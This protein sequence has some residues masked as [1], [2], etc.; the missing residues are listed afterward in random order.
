VTTATARHELAEVLAA[1]L[2]GWSVYPEPPATVHAPALGFGPGDPYRK[3]AGY[4][5][6]DVRL[7]LVLLLSEGSQLVL[8]LMD[9]AIDDVL[10]ILRT[11]PTVSVEQVGQVGQVR[12][13]GGIGYLGA[14]VDVSLGIERVKGAAT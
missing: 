8:D 2:P 14:V 3:P 12:E 5:L 11:Q 9:D 10:A 7:R 13:V 1:G 6:D 4:R